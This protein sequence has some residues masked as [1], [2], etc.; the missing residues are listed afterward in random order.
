MYI[1][2]LRYIYIY[3]NIKKVQYVKMIRI[4][5]ILNILIYI[6]KYKKSLIC[7]ND[8]NFM[9]IKNIKVY[10]YKYEKSLICKNDQ[11]LINIKNIE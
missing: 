8:Q 7:Q 5:W 4:L 2:I 1:N 6:Y 9:N 3:I 11:N 10:I